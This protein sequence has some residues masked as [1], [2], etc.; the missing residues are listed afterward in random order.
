M[1]NIVRKIDVGSR[2]TTTALSQ[3][4]IKVGLVLYDGLPVLLYSTSHHALLPCQ[5]V[6]Q[7]AE[8]GM[9]DTTAICAVL[10]FQLVLAA[11]SGEHKLKSVAG[12]ASVSSFKT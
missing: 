5:L 9:L 8:V 7:E 3:L 1:L 12:R 11:S 2:S 4:R 6:W 10:R